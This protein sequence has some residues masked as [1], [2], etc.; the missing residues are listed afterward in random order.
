M[1]GSYVSSEEFTRWTGEE[2]AFRA[3]LESGIAAQ[4]KPVSDTLGR[5]ELH[6]AQINGRT[7]ANSEAIAELRTRVDVIDREDHR[8]GE[9]V[10]SLRSEGCA[11]YAAHT[12]LINYACRANESDVSGWTDKKKVAVGGGLV[13]TGALVWPALQKLAEA[14]HA[15][16]ERWPLR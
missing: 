1:N 6:L 8:I 10:E 15:L 2:S 13:A 3:R 4:I 7:R 12:K 9:A 5:I 14:V 16:I 11:Q